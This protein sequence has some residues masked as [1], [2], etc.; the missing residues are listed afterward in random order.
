MQVSEVW[1]C[2]GEKVLG[3]NSAGEAER[4]QRGAQEHALYPE[5]SGEL[6]E[7]ADQRA[8]RS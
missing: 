2:M 5:D 3:G 8:T 6:R 4:E 7:V 1:K